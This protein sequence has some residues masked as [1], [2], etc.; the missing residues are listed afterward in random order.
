MSKIFK[1]VFAAVLTIVMIISVMSTA[2]FATAAQDVQYPAIVLDQEQ[3][4]N[5]TQEGEKVYFA[6]TPSESGCYEFI[7][8]AGDGYDTQGF[9]YDSDFNQ[10][11]ENDDAVERNFGVSYS[12]TANTQYYFGAAFLSEN[13]T[14][15]FP[16][17]VKKVEIDNIVFEA[18]K[19]I[20]DGDGFLCDEYNEETEL[21]ETYFKYSWW[22]N[23]WYTVTFADG[24]TT[25]GRGCE[26]YRNNNMY[27]IEFEDNQSP[28]NK[29][30]LGNT[31][32]VQVSALNY[33]ATIPVEVV[34]SPVEEVIVKPVELVENFHGYMA[35]GWNNNTE[36]QEDY[37]EY[38]WQARL[39]YTIKFKN[40]QELTAWGTDF[41]Y[42]DR[43]YH[44]KADSQ[45]SAENKW[46]V[47]NTYTV[48]FNV[49]GYDATAQVSI[50]PLSAVT[51]ELT[52]NEEHTVEV[53]STYKDVFLKLTPEVSSP[54]NFEA[55]AEGFNTEARLYNS[56]MEQIIHSNAEKENNFFFT[57]N[58]EA[59]E[60]YYLK[61]NIADGSTGS[62]PV[63][64]WKMAAVSDI[65]VNPL[66]LLEKMNAKQVEGYNEQTEE[67]EYFYRYDWW[68][69]ISYTI[70]FD[71]DDEISVTGTSFEYKDNSYNLTYT[72][73][74]SPT[75]VWTVGNTYNPTFTVMG[76]TV[77][78]QVTIDEMSAPAIELDVETQANI[79]V[80]GE[81]AF[82]SFIP[83][84]SGNYSFAA[85]AEGEDTFG[86]LYDSNLE[87]LCEND[88]SNSINFVVSYNLEAGEKYYFAARYYS[89]ERTGSF[90]VM[91]SKAPTIT[92][93]EFRP[94]E[95]IANDENCGN[96]N[97]TYF[98]YYWWNRL[99]YTVTID[100]KK[101][102]GDGLWFEYEGKGYEFKYSDDQRENPWSVGNTY[103]KTV[104]LLDCSAPVSVSIVD[105]PIK[106]ID[107]KP[108]TFI[109]NIM[110]YW[111][112]FWNEEE[113]REDR[114]Y[115]YDWEESLSYTITF[116]DGTKVSGDSCWVNYKGAQYRLELSDDQ[117]Y[118]SPW[119]KG[120]TYHPTV[121]IFGYT[122]TVPVTIADNTIKKITVD[123]INLIENA[124]GYHAYD[125]DNEY[126][127]PESYYHYTW[128]HHLSMN[129][130]FASGFQVKARNGY[131]IY[132][133]GYY[134]FD[135]SFDDNQ[136]SQ[137]QWKLGNTY[138][139]SLTVMGYTTTASVK[140]V[141]TP[142]QSIS[143][144]PIVIPANTNG[145]DYGY[146]NYYWRGLK[147]VS[148]T[149]NYKNGAR[150]TY[151]I[152]TEDIIYKDSSYSI[153]SYDNQPEELWS[154]GGTYTASLS[155]LG[156]EAPVS[157]TISENPVEGNVEYV[158]QNGCAVVTGLFGS[159]ETITI[160]ETIEGYPVTSILSL[161]G[162]QYSEIIIPDCVTML[163][164][165][166][167]TNVE[168]LEKITIGAGITALNRRIFAYANALK[169]IEVAKD[170]PEYTSL[171][172]IVYDKE[173]T[174]I[175]AIPNARE[176][177]HVVPDTVVNANAYFD[178]NY[179]FELD[180][181]NS[182]TGYITEDGV[183]Y[184]KD[185]TIVYSCS[186]EKTG[187]YDMPNTV[188]TIADGAFQFSNL[189]EVTISNNV[190]DIV[191]YAFAESINLERVV[192]P[193]NLKSISAKAFVNCSRLS[194]I[195]LPSNLLSIGDGAFENTALTTVNI[196]ASVKRLGS[197]AF[198]YAP[199]E[200]LTLNEGLLEIGPLAFS[201]TD[202]T[203]VDIP[204]SVKTIGYGAFYETN[205]KTVDLGTGVEYIGDSAFGDCW[206]ESVYIPS[207]VKYL[208]KGAFSA[209]NLESVQFSEGLTALNDLAFARTNLKTV[210][211]PESVTDIGYRCF[212]DS[213]DLITIDLPNKLQ[214]LDG[215]AF[216]GTAWYDK[217]PNGVVYIEKAL[218][219]YKGTMPAN[220]KV[221]VKN[222]T[223][224]IADHS[225]TNQENLKTI[226]LPKSIKTIGYKA[227]TNC[228]GLTDVYFYGSKADRD[229]LV[230]E[231]MNMELFD[232]TWHYNY[233]P[234]SYSN[235]CDKTC[236]LCNATRTVGAHRYTNNCDTTCNICNATRRINHAYRDYVTKATL[237]KNGKIVRKCSVCSS[238]YRTTTVYYAKTIKLSA[239]SY[240]YN[241]KTKT[242]TVTVKDSKGKTI[243]KSN[244]TVK[245]ASGRKN[246]GK[247]KVTI[248]FKGNYSGSKTLY[249]KINPVKTSITKLTAAKKALT[250]SISKKT[251]QVTGYEIQYATNKKFSKAKKTTVKS[252]KTTKVTLK[253]LSA[254]KTYYVRV[255]T[256]KTVGKTKYYSGWSTVKY[257][258][259]K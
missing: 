153:Q 198:T 156:Y 204:N 128:Q 142:I 49:L 154:P 85:F 228:N 167:L 42:N 71:N 89:S 45:Q 212:E 214:S 199:I 104:S 26:F 136:S 161:Y 258:K 180:L 117:S 208:G 3:T 69:Y 233:C 67:N 124:D 137:N 99:S 37:F 98:Q 28:V 195:N 63:K 242:P 39:S 246:V 222:G 27:S 179:Q 32:N 248:T 196:P 119:R 232:A 129:I 216:H 218:Y 215:L 186:G 175:V 7:S 157:I 168:G 97:E 92:S 59:G 145:N 31:Y 116:K 207:N 74:Q 169:E 217:Q 4:A 21:D 103:V 23:L 88:D 162:G 197:G 259:T 123:P 184:N 181:S 243:S 163:S 211:I 252:Y 18:T 79:S 229:K 113:Q 109:E 132:N 120:N 83:E 135:L 94:I 41:N 47:N 236:N 100:G 118:E 130:T 223:E 1:R 210:D 230:V 78:A 224:I 66:S 205:I 256:Y 22:E 254:K 221:T 112:Y 200:E 16:V 146:Y 176:E 177:K 76:R 231:N 11:A 178:G 194:D 30:S 107:M 245:Y 166:M 2:V 19:V 111:S 140:I 8:L 148:F 189:S 241:G 164:S 15:S 96:E 35:D 70:K 55:F 57:Y 43:F 202:M 5:I 133:G 239:T 165:D 151:D 24:S 20:E 51:A 192:L 172:G 38:G 171:E 114:W 77:T 73:E 56:N 147:D 13:E 121:S 60:T 80:S 110:G 138:S 53:N 187:S 12:L 244:Y 75:N 72:D 62:F 91:L 102:D 203:H 126:D 143:V 249:F 90:P 134:D 131:F 84:T 87:Q 234:H 36:Q 9:I 33:S 257:K 144:D 250:V 220:T 160:P 237:S 95:I 183:T 219:N 52:L 155:V 93:I 82:F 81:K 68:D 86:H 34:E 25:T 64:V 48:T 191:Y 17:M 159:G 227:F 174:K 213:K 58:L 14:G 150:E 255:R 158:I 225:F 251:K 193:D 108:L 253:K 173:L 206:I 44:I 10:L 209:S 6:F 238:V 54:Y 170:N 240:T 29:W 188:E 115:K 182:G 40:G 201:G 122:A 190:S 152:G 101:Y 127:E 50:V 125:W 61:V 105:T 46:S 235:A 226:I 139:V 149:I 247:Y 65:I 106:S 141:E 185:K